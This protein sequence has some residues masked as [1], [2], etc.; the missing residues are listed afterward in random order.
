MEFTLG[1]LKIMKFPLQKI[2]KKELP[3]KTSWKISKFLNKI[4]NELSSIENERIKLVNKYGKID[5]NTKEIKVPQENENLFKKEFLDFLSVNVNIDCETIKI[6][7]LGDIELTPADLLILS[8]Y[9][10]E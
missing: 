6:E 3:I 2:A 7:D 10:V 8:K 5:D 1:E 4:N 9:V